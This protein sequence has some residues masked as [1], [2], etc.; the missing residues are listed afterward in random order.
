M[1][2]FQK[3]LSFISQEKVMSI[4]YWLI[5]AALADSFIR[6]G[7][8][9]FD[10]EGFWSNSFLETWGFPLWFMYLIGV[11]ELVAG[12]LLLVPKLRH[13]GSAVLALVMLGALLTRSIF[14]VI[15]GLPLE[16]AY[17]FFQDVLFFFST[18]SIF[19]FFI[20]IWYRNNSAAVAAS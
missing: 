19:L 10:S 12:V 2:R 14:A 20:A 11:L 9:K 18:I 17:F 6:N 4:F 5:S 1:Q 13:L 8:R 7:I 3:Q 16:N 15:N